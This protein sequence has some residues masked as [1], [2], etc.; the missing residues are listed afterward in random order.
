[1]PGFKLMTLISISFRRF[2][3]TPKRQYYYYYK[4]YCHECF[5]QR[6]NTHSIEKLRRKHLPSMI[7][8]NQ[9]QK[10]LKAIRYPPLVIT[11]GRHPPLL[12][13]NPYL[14][15]NGHHHHHHYHHFFIFFYYF[16]IAQP[17][18]SPYYYSCRCLLLLLLLF[19]LLLLLF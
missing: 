3:S 17:H 2:H 7:F 10:S 11:S 4:V 9:E 5:F 13:L 1:M 15:F 12:F 16:L 19:L 14:L 18:G 8:I 6:K